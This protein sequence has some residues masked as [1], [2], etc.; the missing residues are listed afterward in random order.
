MADDW[1]TL[2]SPYELLDRWFCGFYCFI[3]PTLHHYAYSEQFDWLQKQCYTSIKS[4]SRNLGNIFLLPA[5]KTYNNDN[6]NTTTVLW[7]KWNYI[8]MNYYFCGFYRCVNSGKSLINLKPF[9]LYSVSEKFTQVYAS[10]KIHKNKFHSYNNCNSVI[11]GQGN[12]QNERPCAVKCS[13]D[14][15]RISP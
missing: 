10:I 14:C 13:L 3:I 6:E 7:Q 9:G 15:E 1:Y 4:M 2:S 8:L 11:S 12:D 5:A